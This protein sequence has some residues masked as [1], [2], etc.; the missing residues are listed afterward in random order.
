MAPA[1]WCA[2][3]HCRSS[4]SVF[5]GAFGPRVP[6]QASKSRFMPYLNTTEQAASLPF[7]LSSPLQTLQL[8]KLSPGSLARTL[9]MSAGSTTT[10]PC[11]FRHRDRLG[12]DPSLVLVQPA[13]RLRRSRGRHLVVEVGARDADA[14][15]L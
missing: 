1:F 10:A 9:G 12:H 5:T 6:S 2:T 13:A 11:C 14:R 7:A 8:R 4:V 15:T 3:F